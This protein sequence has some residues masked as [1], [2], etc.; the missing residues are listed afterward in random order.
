MALEFF[1]N[2]SSCDLFKML[3]LTMKLKCCLV[4]YKAAHIS[5]NWV[6]VQKVEK[7]M[8]PFWPKCNDFFVHVPHPKNS[9][10]AQ[11]WY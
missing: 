10:K 9:L 6:S 7:M 2:P 5:G 4:Y 8:L 1:Q 3:L 11:M